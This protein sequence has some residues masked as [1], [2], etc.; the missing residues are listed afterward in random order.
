MAPGSCLGREVSL[1]STPSLPEETQLTCRRSYIS[2][3]CKTGLCKDCRGATR[4]G[5]NH[6]TDRG[7][8]SGPAHA[9]LIVTRVVEDHLCLPCNV[10][11]RGCGDGW[12]SAHPCLGACSQDYGG[13]VRIQLHADER[14]STTGCG[15]RRWRAASAQAPRRMPSV[16][17][18]TRFATSVASARVG[19]GASTIVS[20]CHIVDDRLSNHISQR[21]SH[22]A[23]KLSTVRCSSWHGTAVQ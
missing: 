1:R 15:R 16:P 21:S 11:H 6:S 4:N 20:T 9:C 17:S 7:L 5:A 22:V 8:P 12:V 23:A 3:R 19:R 2:R 10:K 14:R 13:A 18:S